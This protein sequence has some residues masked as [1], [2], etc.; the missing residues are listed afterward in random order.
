[1]AQRTLEAHLRVHHATVNLMLHNATVDFDPGTVA[2]GAGRGGR[3]EQGVGG[4][5]GGAPLDRG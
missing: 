4:A 2:P 3:R 1:M 5:A